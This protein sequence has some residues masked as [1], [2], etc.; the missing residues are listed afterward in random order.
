MLKREGE[1]LADL[2]K[3]DCKKLYKITGSKMRESLCLHVPACVYMY[4][5]VSSKQK[6]NS[7]RWK[8][9]A[10]V[11]NK[12]FHGAPVIIVT[13]DNTHIIKLLFLSPF[14]ISLFIFC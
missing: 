1:M 2:W 11:K 5:C 12:K 14:L 3:N 8:T 4:V 6:I 10:E 13:S 9:F 7:F